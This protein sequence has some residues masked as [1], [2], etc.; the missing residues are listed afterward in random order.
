MDTNDNHS[1]NT[2]AGKISANLTAIRHSKHI[3]GMVLISGTGSYPLVLKERFDDNP[4]QSLL[5]IKEGQEYIPYT[6]RYIDMLNSDIN[7]ILKPI[8]ESSDPN[9]RSYKSKRKR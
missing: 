1:D 6:R 7:K 8:K 9:T 4:V 3:F 2:E 5:D